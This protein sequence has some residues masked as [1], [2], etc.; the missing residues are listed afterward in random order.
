M[1]LNIISAS[2]TIEIKQI[3]GC[4]YGQ[5][6]TGKTSAGFTASRP[7]LL[8]FD[9]GAHR[10]AYRKDSVPVDD[11]STVAA[12]TREDLSAY[13]TL[14]I[15]TAGRALDMLTADI[16]RR[17]AKLGNGLGGLNQRGYGALKSTFA[18]WLRGVHTLG[19]DVIL[20][21]HD[22]ES[23]DGDDVTVRPDITGGSYHEIFKLADFIGY[24]YAK[25]GKRVMQFAPTDVSVGKDPAGFG[26]MDVPDFSSEPT[27]LADRIAEVKSR[28]GQLSADGQRVV[29]EVAELREILSA[30]DEAEHINEFQSTVAE[31]KATM[32][33]AS[34]EQ[35]RAL[36]RARAKDIGAVWDKAA[37]GWVEVDT[38]PET[39]E[40]ES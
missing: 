7:L 35:M 30:C 10:S 16:I 24:Q 37:G 1:P 4:I 18:G 34:L 3:T 6:G 25:G 40:P 39:E 11:W 28:M 12:I 21:A 36:V 20:L 15:D 14:V 27:W 22:K 31:R 17:D 19:L 32:H 2:E 5:P 26:R 33:P 8:D 29:T 13:D 38:P 9:K 23:R